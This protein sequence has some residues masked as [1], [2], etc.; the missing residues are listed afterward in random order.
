[1]IISA[2][3]THKSADMKALELIGRHDEKA[4]LHHLRRIQGV[5]ECAVLRTCNRVELYAVTDEPS[6]TRNGMEAMVSRFIPFDH[7]QN[8]VQFRSDL[9]SI[10][11]LLR[12]SSG[13]ESMIVGEDQIQFQVK[14]AYELAESEGCIGP[15]LSL[16]F[17]KAISVGKKVRTETKVNKGAV[18]IG[19]AAVDLAERLL[20]SLEGKTILVIGAGEMATLIAK[21]LIEKRPNAIFVS[22]RTYDRAVELAWYLGGQA[23]RLDSLYDY[24]H[25]CDIVLVAT[26]SPHVILDRARVEKAIAKKG[27]GE[28]LIIIDVSFPRNVAD[29]VRLLKNVEMH[30]IDGLRDI[31]QENIMRRKK[32]VFEAERIIAEELSLLEKKLEEMGA[33][34]VIRAL[35]QK[36][37][38]IKEVE[39]RKAIN[40]LNHSSEDIE[41]IVTDFANALANR[42]LADPTEMLKL[43]SREKRVEI[44]KAARELF[45]L[46]ESKN[47]S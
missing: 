27:E 40:R 12:V 1:M 18:S 17:R 47:V 25:K 15:I 24:L 21:H 9:E 37:E 8:L 10:R 32:E 41:T 7:E 30:D 46:E 28:K 5:K 4:L 6:T 16:I 45:R 20:G 19:S 34:E 44:L 3:V 26:S 43:A 2:H 29:D 23:I 33:S 35:R 36:F 31:A 38:A 13:L 22:N 14:R 39:I 42:F 11:H